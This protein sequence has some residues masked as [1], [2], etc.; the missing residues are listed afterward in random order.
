MGKMT[1]LNFV[2]KRNGLRNRMS[3]TKREELTKTYFLQ[4]HGLQRKG[5]IYVGVTKRLRLQRKERKRVCNR[6][7]PGAPT[8]KMKRKDDFGCIPFNLF[9]LEP[10]CAPVKTNP[11]MKVDN[12]SICKNLF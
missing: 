9:T 3:K 1:I 8:K 7:C 5:R 4:R 12:S 6:Q 2:L 11:N 10:P